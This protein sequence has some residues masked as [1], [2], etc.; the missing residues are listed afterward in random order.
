MEEKLR[1]TD[2]LNDAVKGYQ[3]IASVRLD[4]E[5]HRLELADD[6][7]LLHDEAAPSLALRLG[8]D[9]VTQVMHCSQ[10]SSAACA[11]CAQLQPH[12]AT[13][14]AAP[15]TTFR[16]GAMEIA[17]HPTTL[18]SAEVNHAPRSLGETAATEVPG[19][20][21]EPVSRGLD[22]GKL[23]GAFT[24]MTLVATIAAGVLSRQGATTV[25]TVLSVMAFAAG[26]YYG[27]IDGVA[28]L[29]A[30]R[31]DVNRLM[32]LAALGAAF[33]GQPAAGAV[34]L[35]LF[36]L[37]NT[38]QAYALD[39]NRRTISKLLDLRPPQ[40]TVKRGSAAVTLPVPADRSV[41][42]DLSPGKEPWRR[43]AIS[44]DPLAAPLLTA[45]KPA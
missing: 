20:P 35:F 23:E 24:A 42:R 40:A 37:S 27:L 18:A 10:K 45:R 12:F 8:R 2:I 11:Y 36:S 9:A 16:D 33:I 7:R 29:K 14:A 28:A 43:T 25:M 22:R 31:L 44:L 21:A 6:P 34:L 38:L 19:K 4:V 17:L 32:I 3:G 30:K 13:R 1:C 5:R 39:R 26:G 15:T 41:S